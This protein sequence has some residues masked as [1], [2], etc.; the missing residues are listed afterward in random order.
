M[1]G[2]QLTQ[3]KSMPNYQY[4]CTNPFRPSCPI[5]QNNNHFNYVCVGERSEMTSGKVFHTLEDMLRIHRLLEK[6][7]FIK[8]DCEGG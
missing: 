6:H 1:V 2:C 7:I 8:I 4:D 5:N 3:Q